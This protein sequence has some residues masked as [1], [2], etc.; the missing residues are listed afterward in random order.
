M[1]IKNQNEVAAEPG[2]GPGYVIEQGETSRLEGRLLTLIEAIG[3]P[4]KQEE[5][6]KGLIRQELWNSVSSHG[7]WIT[8][9]QHTRLRQENKGIGQST[10][11]LL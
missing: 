1:S 3:M 9:E 6:L 5:A 10:L 2:W 8:G 4:D 11:S 7:L